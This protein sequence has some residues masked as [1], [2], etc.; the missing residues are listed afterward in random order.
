MLNLKPAIKQKKQTPDPNPCTPKAPLQALREALYRGSRIGAFRLWRIAH[1]TEFVDNKK[2]P[3]SAPQK[4]RIGRMR[5]GREGVCAGK[6]MNWSVSEAP[7]RV[8]DELARQRA[9]ADTRHQ[10]ALQ[11]PDPKPKRTKKV[12]QAGGAHPSLQVGHFEG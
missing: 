10:A 6:T 5:A 3:P 1:W 2:Q 4:S 11:T 9:A 8:P 12:P 7:V